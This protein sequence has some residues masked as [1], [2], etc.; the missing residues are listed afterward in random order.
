MRSSALLTLAIIVV[1][2]FNAP[3]KPWPRR[4]A[5][6][7]DGERFYA[8][9]APR[10]KFPVSVREWMSKHGVSRYKGE[11]VMS[12]DSKTGAVRSVHLAT[13]TGIDPLDQACINTFRKWVFERSPV[14]YKIRC[15]VQLVYPFKGVKDKS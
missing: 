9:N 4:Y 10:P 15:P 3:G 11:F 2:A 13:S 14:N 12:I 5:I 6:G 8:I 1:S 7:P